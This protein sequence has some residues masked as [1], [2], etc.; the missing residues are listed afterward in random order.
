M[1]TSHRPYN[2][3]AS[4]LNK[5]LHEELAELAEIEGDYALAAYHWTQAAKLNANAGIEIIESFLANAKRN[6]ELIFL[7]NEWE[8]NS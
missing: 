3:N 8:S 5:G 2:P 6:Q 7:L 1:K 4:D